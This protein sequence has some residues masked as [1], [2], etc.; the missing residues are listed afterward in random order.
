MLAQTY[1]YEY[2]PGGTGSVRRNAIAARSLYRSR[3]S[4]VLS[5]TSVRQLCG[6]ITFPQRQYPRCAETVNVLAAKYSQSRLRA[7]VRREASRQAATAT[8]RTFVVRNHSLVFS[9]EPFT[10]AG[11]NCRSARGELV[12]TAATR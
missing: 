8:H 11:E 10:E 2:Q 6:E 12:S 3:P 5:H 9:V 4:S 1:L 7:A